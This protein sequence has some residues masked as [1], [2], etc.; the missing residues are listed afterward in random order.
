MCSIGVNSSAFSCVR[1]T[2]RFVSMEF[3]ELA[4]LADL[5]LPS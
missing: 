2:E 4:E 1:H 5:L 3:A